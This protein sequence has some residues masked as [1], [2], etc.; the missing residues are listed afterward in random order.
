[1]ATPCH[2]PMTQCP[3]HEATEQQLKPHDFSELFSFFLQ[4]VKKV[5]LGFYLRVRR[6]IGSYRTRTHSRDHHMMT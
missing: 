1:M 3:K 2:T 5:P 6:L 4:V